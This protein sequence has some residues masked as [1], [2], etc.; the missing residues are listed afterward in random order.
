MRRAWLAGL[1]LTILSGCSL[2]LD[3]SS[4]AIPVD[5]EI[6]APYTLEECQYME[7]NDS[8]DAAMLFTPAD[9]GPA[10]ICAGDVEDRDFYKFTVPANT[11]SVTVSISFMN[12]PTGDLELKLTDTAGMM[13]GQSRGFGNEEKIVCPATSPPCGM[14]MPGDYVFEVFPALMGSVNNYSIALTITPM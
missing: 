1:P 8:I 13:K 10:A 11:A 5:A 14:L 2:V 6:D 7:P 9:V 4:S 12:R 3:F